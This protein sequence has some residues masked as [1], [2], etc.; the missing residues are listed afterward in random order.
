MK[1]VLY[2]IILNTAIVFSSS[3]ALL[4]NEAAPASSGSDWVELFL[5]EG[6]EQQ[7]DISRLYV[8]M[9]Y[10]ANEPLC[11]EPVTI[12]SYNRPETP[13]DDRFVVV[14]LTDP[15]TPDETDRTGDTNGNGR[16]DLYCNNY[17]SSLWNTD[18]VVA[19]D[20]DD[21]PGN[22][23]I[24]D[25]MAFSNRDGS[26]NGTMVSYMND[27]ANAGQWSLIPGAAP[28]ECMV[29]IGAG[30]FREFMTIARKGSGDTN[31]LSDFA[32]TSFQT[33]GG[34]N[35]F[36]GDLALCS[37]VFSA[38]R[39]RIT[40]IP[41]HSTLGSAAVPLTIYHGCSVRLRIFTP[42]GMLIYQSPLYSDVQPGFF[43]LPWNLR[44][45]HRAARSGLYIGL[46]EATSREIRSTQEEKIFIIVSRS[47]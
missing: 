7:M 30:D 11:A 12:Y 37:R 6:G 19:I 44:G 3:G 39:R 43:S 13:W 40:V 38:D 24:I 15:V 1:Q 32:V 14:H 2:A 10:G 17:T 31:G 46:I 20:S 45:N 8:T 21:D 4:I 33:P 29:N 22:G 23:G 34:E 47:R 36:S 9:Y 42:V 26:P 35:R 18:C 41:G 27:A 28:Q 16:I 25:F 5:P